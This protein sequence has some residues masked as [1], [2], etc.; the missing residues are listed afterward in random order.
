MSR[1]AQA[2]YWLLTIPVEHHP[3]QPIIK[4]DLVYI[5]GQ[6]E[7]GGDTGYLHWQLM[8]VFSKKLRLAAVKRHFCAQAH[9][10]ASRSAAA[11]EYVWKEDT[12]VEGTQFE[13]GSLPVSRARTLDWDRIY[14][15]AIAGDFESIPKDILIRN[16]SALKR[17]RVDNVIPPVRPGVTVNTYWG[18]SGTGKTRRAWYE[19]GTPA[20]VYIKNPNTKWWDGY[21]GQ[22]TVIIDEFTGRIDITYLLTWLDRYPCL[23]EVKGYS[24]PLLATRF[25][26]TSN[27]DPRNWYPE[28]NPAQQAA[29]LRRMNITRFL[30]PWNPPSDANLD[31]LSEVAL[32]EQLD[33]ARR[34]RPSGTSPMG[35]LLGPQGPSP[36]TIPDNLF[37]FFD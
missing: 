15:S 18:E 30:L 7:Q 10:E 5:K 34:A 25:F 17:I 28:A 6:Q 4:D 19:A 14:D 1:V 36:S 24:T 11:S 12:R 29:L 37:D 27:V 23:V 16:Y 13:A 32:A 21:R 26:I 20:T 33:S 3:Q 31:L 8:A 2:R 35:S 9:C 22:E